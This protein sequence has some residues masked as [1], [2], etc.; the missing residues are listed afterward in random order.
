MSAILAGR[1]VAPTPQLVRRSDGLSLLYPE[2]IHSLA[3]ES[4][5]ASQGL[6]WV[7]LWPRCTASPPGSHTQRHRY[8]RLPRASSSTGGGRHRR[9]DGAVTASNSTRSRSMLASSAPCC[10]QA[11]SS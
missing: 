9:S 2:K 10:C 3:G 11:A 1:Y 6:G 7:P 5:A 4:E 8:G